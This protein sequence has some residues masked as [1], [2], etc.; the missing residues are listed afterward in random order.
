[1]EFLVPDVPRRSQR[2]ADSQNDPKG[3]LLARIARRLLFRMDVGTAERPATLYLSSVDLVPMGSWV[4]VAEPS[5][6][7]TD[8][9]H[10]S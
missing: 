6:A 7:E 1:M 9:S 4:V 3:T 8:P 5:Q 10:S 2:A